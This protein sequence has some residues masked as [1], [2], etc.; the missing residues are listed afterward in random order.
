[1]VHEF[2]YPVVLT[3]DETDGGFVVTFPLYRRLSPREKIPRV[4]WRKPPMPWRRRSPDGSGGAIP[5]RGH[6]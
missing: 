2:A 4:R 1:M 3:P 6:P 5:S